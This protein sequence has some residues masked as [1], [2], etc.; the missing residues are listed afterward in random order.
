MKFRIFILFIMLFASKLINA[1][2]SYNYAKVFPLGNNASINSRISAVDDLGNV[3]LTGMFSSS[4]DA[5]PGSNTLLLSSNPSDNDIYLIK[6][7]PNGDLLWAKKIGGTSG[8]ENVFDIA[9]DASGVYISGEFISTVDFDPNAGVANLVGGGGFFAKYDV[10]G[11]YILAKQIVSSF[12]GNCDHIAVDSAKNI[13]IASTYSAP[14]NNAG[15]VDVDPHPTNTLIFNV[16]MTYDNMYFCKYDSVGNL[17]WGKQIVGK[18]STAQ[19]LFVHKDGSIYISGQYGYSGND[20]DPSTATSNIL[21]TLNATGI[22]AYFAKYSNSGNLI[23]IKP[24]TCSGSYP[25]STS[26]NSIKIGQQNNIYLAGHFDKTV[27]FNPSAAVANKISN[28]FKDGFVASYDSVGNYKWVNSYGGANTELLYSMDIDAKDRTYFT[29]YFK[30][31]NIDFDPSANTKF[32]SASVNAGFIGAYDSAGAFLFA[33]KFSDSLS[34]GKGVTIK[35]NNLYVTGNFSDTADF[36]F[37]PMIV[38]NQNAVANANVFL[39]KQSISLFPLSIS[40]INAALVNNNAIRISWMDDDASEIVSYDIEKI[41]P[42]GN[43]IIG[44]NLDNT[45]TD[46]LDLQPTIGVNQY[47]VISNYTN[48]NKKYSA[49]ASCYYHA[50]GKTIVSFDNKNIFINNQENKSISYKLLSITGQL[51][52]E[53]SMKGHS[54]KQINCSNY[55]HG[56]LLLQINYG[57][58]V[59]VIKLLNQ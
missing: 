30:G 21:T 4:I 33:E 2:L 58:H 23:F 49:T 3:Y 38:N 1:Q 16:G 46:F 53:A 25:F 55:A 39:S 36:N 14:G 10:N 35:N 31:T 22:N 20:F 12:Y 15:T 54:Q 37:D 43:K 57:N 9:V 44:T 48:G 5:D 19:D 26:I 32:L 27:D 6:L 52:Q 7:D 11:N 8:D 59:E 29:G 50:Q 42:L 47:Q 34:V 45:A 40:Y 41:E 24:I 56:I 17:V 28:G 51:L 18:L 13:Y